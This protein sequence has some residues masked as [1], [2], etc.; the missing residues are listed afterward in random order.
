VLLVSVG[1]HS[2]LAYAVAARRRELAIRMALGAAPRTLA[3]SVARQTT[4]MLAPGVAV[5]VVAAVLAA[6]ALRALLYEVTP[7]DPIVFAV[8]MLGV[9][10]VALGSAYVP[11][12]RAARVNPVVALKE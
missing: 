2:V 12:R 4:A 9:T 11:A 5:G 6:P 10:A 1:V 8:T 7:T 3:W